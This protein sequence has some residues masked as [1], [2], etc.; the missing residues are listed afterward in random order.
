MRAVAVAVFGSSTVTHLG[1]TCDDSTAEVAVVTAHPRVD[2]V[3]VHPRTCEVVGV[4]AVERARPLIDAVET[5][6][7]WVCLVSFDSDDGVLLDEKNVG[8]IGQYR[9]LGLVESGSES[10]DCRTDSSEDVGAAV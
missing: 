3:R 4:V 9:K 1:A 7:R 5:P 8:V 6:R 10:I 2:D